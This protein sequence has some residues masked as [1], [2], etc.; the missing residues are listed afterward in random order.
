[1]GFVH[2]LEDY[3]VLNPVKCINPGSK[4]CFMGNIMNMI[5]IILY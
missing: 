1:M 5:D 4:T 2:I 3:P